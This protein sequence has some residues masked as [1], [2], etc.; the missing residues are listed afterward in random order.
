MV[1]KHRVGMTEL[2]QHIFAFFFSFFEEESLPIAFVFCFFGM[3][4]E[5]M[6]GLDETYPCQKWHHPR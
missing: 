4:T 5:K 2:F 1:R 6:K 3:K